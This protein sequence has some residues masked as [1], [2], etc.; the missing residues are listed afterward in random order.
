MIRNEVT[1][2]GTAKFSGLF[3][4]TRGK[5][6]RLLNENGFRAHYKR[7]PD[8]NAEDGCCYTIYLANGDASEA[9][10]ILQ[11]GHVRLTG[12]LGGGSQS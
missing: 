6:I 4:H 9:L 2:Y 11:K 1:L 3:N 7:S 8:P 10:S 5:G 12:E